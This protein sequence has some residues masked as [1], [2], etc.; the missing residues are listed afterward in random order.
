MKK[1]FWKSDWFAGLVISLF[2]LFAGSSALLQSV[3]R[4]AYDLGVQSSSRNAGNKIAI[5]AIDNQSI[6]NIG[7]WPWSRE[8]HAKMTEKLAAAKAKVIGNTIYFLEPQI[9]PGLS[10]INKISTFVASSSI[11]S[12]AEAP[13]LDAMLK[14]AQSALNAD[15]KLATA[16][17]LAN[18]VV[19]AMPFTIGEPRGNPDKPLPAYVAKNALPNILDRVH[20]EENGLL[21]Y[22]TLAALSPIPI[23]GEAAAAIGHLN[24]NPD[25]DGATRAEPLVLAFYDQYYPSLSLQIAAKYLNLGPKDIKVNLGE[26][27]QLGK[28][29]IVTDTWLQMN[30]FFYSGKKGQSAFPID[31]FFDVYSG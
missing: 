11:V 30:T 15:A 14:E 24:A 7:R 23:I 17:K 21:P 22:Q 18:N 19:I 28:L 10:Y 8:I 9:D 31:S 27:V 6:D 20:A 29:N 13:Q 12:T 3:E 26:G 2:F 16:V 5:I 4:K 1:G 25:V